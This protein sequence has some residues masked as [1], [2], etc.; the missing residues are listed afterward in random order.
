[1]HLAS[2]IGR[3]LLGLFLVPATGLA[4]ER[5]LYDA[6]RAAFAAP[7][8]PVSTIARSQE[9]GGS[10]DSVLNGVLIGTGAGAAAG[11]LGAW[12]WCQG[13]YKGECD[14]EPGQ[15]PLRARM[16]LIGA[17]VGAVVGWIIDLSRSHHH[18][19]DQQT[20]PSHG[21]TLVV[22]PVASPSKK[23]LQVTLRY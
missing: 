21:P 7:A 20:L 6:A 12:A 22:A 15:G 2:L 17:G 3:L 4:R 9:S 18:A 16:A 1:M 23:A 5:P 13:D 10:R 14:D 19:A 11:A 8:G